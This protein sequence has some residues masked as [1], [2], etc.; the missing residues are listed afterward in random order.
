MFFIFLGKS[1][2]ALMSGV[3]IDPASGVPDWSS[4]HKPVGDLFDHGAL[5]NKYLNEMLHED[6]S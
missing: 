4:I 1:G 2:V 3:A 6:M 5:V